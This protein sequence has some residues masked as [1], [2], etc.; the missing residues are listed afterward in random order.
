MMKAALIYS[1]CA[2]TSA[3]ATYVWPSKYDSIDD[4]YYLSSGYISDGTLSDRGCLDDLP[5]RSP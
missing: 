4:M 1:L 2:A 5:N 3:S